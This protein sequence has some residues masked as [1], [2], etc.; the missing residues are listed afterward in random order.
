M[1]RRRGDERAETERDGHG[2][3]RGRRNGDANRG[4]SGVEGLGRDGNAVAEA[5][6]PRRNGADAVGADA[7]G[8]DAVGAAEGWRRGRLLAVTRRGCGRRD[9]GMAQPGT[10]GMARTAAGAARTSFLRRRRRS[11][12]RGF[13]GGDGSDRGAAMAVALRWDARADCDAALTTVPR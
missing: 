3:R 2:Q 4:G 10:R 11:G 6:P 12:R 9:C 7:I 1:E 8:V 13:A 5:G